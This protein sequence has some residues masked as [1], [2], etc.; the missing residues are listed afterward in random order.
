MSVLKNDASSWTVRSVYK[1]VRPDYHD[2]Y[3]MDCYGN[4][5]RWLHALRST[6][7]VPRLLVAW[8]AH[9]SGT[10]EQVL[11]TEYVGEPVTAHTLPL[12]WEAQRDRI[13][14]A[15]RAHNCRHNDI[16]P[17]E[18]LVHEGTLRLVDFG[19]ASPLDEPIPAHYPDCLGST[20]RCPTG[21]DDRYSFDAAVRSVLKHPVV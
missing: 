21:L 11:V 1:V 4:E 14:G 15:L 18:L 3:Q 2:K 5:K 13:L 9:P 17:A 6:D 8:D 20:W 12:D 7:V 19:W 10:G 16:K